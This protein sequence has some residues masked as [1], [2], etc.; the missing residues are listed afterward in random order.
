MALRKP[1]FTV[2]NTLVIISD[3]C[4]L[5]FSVVQLRQD[6]ADIQPCQI[7]IFCRTWFPLISVNKENSKA[8]SSAG[9]HTIISNAALLQDQGHKSC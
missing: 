2:V 1:Q 5:I 6:N 4:W 9:S 3:H 7:K 8:S